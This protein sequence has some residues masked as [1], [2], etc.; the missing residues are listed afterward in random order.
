MDLRAVL[1]DDEQLARDELV[2]LLG[3]VGGVELIG[4]AGNGVE[5]LD[6]IRRLQPDWSFSTCRCRG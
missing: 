3:Q 5:A 4:Q 2:Y 1:V 6:T